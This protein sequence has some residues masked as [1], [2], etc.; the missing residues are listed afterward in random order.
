MFLFS[1]IVLVGIAGV[2]LL[3]RIMWWW[4][5]RRWKLGAPIISQPRSAGAGPLYSMN[6]DFLHFFDELRGLS[7]GGTLSPDARALPY[8]P[9]IYRTTDGGSTWEPGTILGECTINAV[10]AFPN[11]EI[12]LLTSPRSSVGPACVSIQIS[13]DYGTTWKNQCQIEALA[14]ASFGTSQ[15][16]VVWGGSCLFDSDCDDDSGESHP[17]DIFVKF[18]ADGGASWERLTIPDDAVKRRAF[19]VHPDGSIFYFHRDHLI[20]LRRDDGLRWKEQSFAMPPSC[21]FESCRVDGETV[22]II[23]RQPDP[24]AIC[25]FRWSEHGP[26]ELCGS[27]G[28]RFQIGKIASSGSLLSV[29]A[30][31]RTS[32]DYGP[33]P[34]MI[35]FRSLDGGRHW[36][37]ERPGVEFNR[38]VAFFSSHAWVISGANRILRRC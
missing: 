29:K 26:W 23:A 28:S 34:G 36:S 4:P 13:K 15:T 37:R 33:I 24:S 6:F 32:Y 27:F 7:I 17:V 30:W 5:S 9:R 1:A 2:I 25:I 12:V 10:E 14:G 35:I 19:D 18:T 11:G 31:P 16:G 22:W 38:P 3:V 8:T 21:A 20:R